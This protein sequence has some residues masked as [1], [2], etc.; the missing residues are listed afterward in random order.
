MDF[1]APFRSFGERW[2]VDVFQSDPEAF[3]GGEFR[4]TR[5]RDRII[6]NR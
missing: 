2:K 6:M 4:A 5:Q 1:P 3:C